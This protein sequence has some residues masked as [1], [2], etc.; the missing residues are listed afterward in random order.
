MSVW[1]SALLNGGGTH[2]AQPMPAAQRVPRSIEKPRAKPRRAL[3]LHPG[4]PRGGEPQ[5]YA[6]QCYR[7]HDFKLQ[8]LRYVRKHSYKPRQ[9]RRL[10]LPS[11][12]QEKA[13]AARGHQGFLLARCSTALR[14]HR[15]CNPPARGA[16]ETR[17]R[18]LLLL[19]LG[20]A[21][22]SAALAIPGERA[23]ALLHLLPSPRCLVSCC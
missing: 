23:P 7:G 16:P 2:A 19:L 1:L 3:A 10:A 14:L 17:C 12:R 18:L 6:R 4:E 21:E 8:R 13:R 9:N 11:G 15:S 20:S 5:S 22:V